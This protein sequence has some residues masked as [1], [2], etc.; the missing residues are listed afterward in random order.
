MSRT[1]FARILGVLL[2]AAGLPASSLAQWG[3]TSLEWVE[4]APLDGD[5]VNR[6]LTAYDTGRY[7][8]FEQ[9]A[10][11]LAS[12]PINPFEFEADAERWMNAAPDRRR[13]AFVAATV[14]LELASLAV[15]QTSHSVP[16]MSD[17]DLQQ[18]SERR[19]QTCFAR[20]PPRCRSMC[21]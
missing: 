15:H 18:R 12:A 9:L 3:P 13:R 14:A 6:L 19:R 4:P 5:I 17:A 7:A 11:T 16:A 1:V 2:L 20:E 21:Q 8:D 10:G